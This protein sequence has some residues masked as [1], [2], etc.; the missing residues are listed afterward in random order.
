M[1]TPGQLSVAVA[2]P[3]TEGIVSFVQE[4][5]AVGGHVIT[6]GTVSMVW[7]PIVQVLR[8]L[9]QSVTVKVIVVLPQPNMIAG[10]TTS[11]LI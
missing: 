7:I 2:V 9:H 11:D 5:V 10:L 3:V 4:T 6:G 1:I 8:L